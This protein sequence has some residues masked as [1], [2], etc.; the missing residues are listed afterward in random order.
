MLKL[1][2]RLDSIAICAQFFST[3]Q[4]RITLVYEVAFLLW[5]D[6]FIIKITWTGPADTPVIFS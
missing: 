3:A 2:L 4:M 6:I 1:V 5:A